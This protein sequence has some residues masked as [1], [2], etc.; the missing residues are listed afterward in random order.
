[1]SIIW[2]ENT[3]QKLC[4]INQCLQGCYLVISIVFILFIQCRWHVL[5]QNTV[6]YFYPRLTN[7]T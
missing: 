3:K 5:L 4:I 7:A 1:M 6:G 2:N